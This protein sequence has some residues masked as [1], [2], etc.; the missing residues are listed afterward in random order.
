M[1]SEHKSKSSLAPHQ[2]RVLDERDEVSARLVKLSAFL[3]GEIFFGLDW[4]EQNRLKRQRSIMTQYVEV[5]DERIEV[6][7]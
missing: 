4:E 1:R 7:S 5:L 2:Q 3:D 6:F